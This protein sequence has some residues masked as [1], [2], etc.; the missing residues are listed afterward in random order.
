MKLTEAIY[1]DVARRLKNPSQR[2]KVPVI[3]IAY[4]YECCAQEISIDE[5]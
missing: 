3:F 5:A 2:T 1:H 4:I